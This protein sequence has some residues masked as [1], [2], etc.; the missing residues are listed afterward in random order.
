[1]KNLSV[2]VSHF[3]NK[4]QQ[5]LLKIIDNFSTYKNFNVDLFINYANDILPIKQLLKKYNAQSINI[6]FELHQK[7]IGEKLVFQ[8]RKEIIK[9]LWCDNSDYILYVE[10]DILIPEIAI[11]TAIDY[12]ENV[13]GKNQICGFLRY[14]E[15]DNKKYLIELNKSFP[16]INK[17]KDDYF[18]IHNIHQGCWLLSLKNVKK[19]I[20]FFNKNFYIYKNHPRYGCLE[21]GATGL[22]CENNE[23][24]KLFEKIY[25]KKDLDNLLIHHLSNK[26][27]NK[28]GVWDNPGAFTI[29]ELKEKIK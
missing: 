14:E 19:S 10:D 18:T 6:F 11:L 5:Y 2:F 28:G 26:Y 27:I 29:N 1:M 24:V 12:T 22:F 15:K 8:H 7:E 3:G 23:G 20:E 9:G 21:Q 4:N 13:F 17:I 25:P 16:T